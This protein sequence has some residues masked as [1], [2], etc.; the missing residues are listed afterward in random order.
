[1]VVGDVIA[2]VT[3]IVIVMIRT[4]DVLILHKKIITF[5]IHNQGKSTTLLLIS[6]HFLSILFIAVLISERLRSCGTSYSVEGPL[7]G[8]TPSSFK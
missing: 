2:T 7:C 4:R 1:M 6:K 5:V 8:I 3:A